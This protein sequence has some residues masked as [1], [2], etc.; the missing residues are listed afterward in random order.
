[1]C[2]IHPDF[3][4]MARIAHILCAIVCTGLMLLACFLPRS[5][6]GPVQGEI[7]PCF[8]FQLLLMICCLLTAPAYMGYLPVLQDVRWLTWV[9]GAACI[10][11][12]VRS[13]FVHGRRHKL[14][15]ARRYSRYAL[16]LYGLILTSIIG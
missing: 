15:T 10:V 11:V 8:L 5:A 9:S 1:M 13:L 16:A 3:F 2:V 7:K 14:R 12:H 4:H 6:R